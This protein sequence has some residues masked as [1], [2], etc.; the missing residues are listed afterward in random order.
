MHSRRVNNLADQD[1]NSNPTVFLDEPSLIYVGDEY[2]Q[3]DD[4]PIA[5]RK[6]TKSCIQEPIHI[7]MSLTINLIKIIN[8]LFYICL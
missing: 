7:Y 4:L 8:V 1:A 5:L 2:E 6:G 3:A